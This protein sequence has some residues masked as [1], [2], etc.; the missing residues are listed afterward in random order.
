MPSLATSKETIGSFF[1]SVTI[2][3]EEQFS[4][5]LI[6]IANNCLSSCLGVL[7]YLLQTVGVKATNPFIKEKLYESVQSVIL[8]EDS[9]ACKKGYYL[10]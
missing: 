6:Q 1:L 8:V 10:Q 4:P 5:Q 9:F 3:S 7:H 2:N